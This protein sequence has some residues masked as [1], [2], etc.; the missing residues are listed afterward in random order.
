M[1]GQSA[2][3]ARIVVTV[4]ADGMVHAE[5]QGVLGAAC[6][7]YVAILEDLVGGETVRSRYTADYR[8]TTI[9]QQGYQEQH[10]IEHA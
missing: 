4:T 6:L 2:P 3:G 7:D 9:D 10:G 5:T 1:T 8:R